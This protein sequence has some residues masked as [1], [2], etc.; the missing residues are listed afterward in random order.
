MS[1]PLTQLAKHFI[2]LKALQDWLK[3]QSFDAIK[4]DVVLQ[5]FA[6]KRNSTFTAGLFVNPHPERVEAHG[7]GEDIFWYAGAVTSVSAPSNQDIDDEAEINRVLLW[8]EN[9]YDCLLP[10]TDIA[11]PG[12]DFINSIEVQPGALFDQTGYA[13]MYDVSQVI[14]RGRTVK[15]RG[16]QNAS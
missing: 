7:S 14:V 15:T 4:R 10:L 3:G 16:T 1:K 2:F 9:M 5:R 13:L 6:F 11:L 12:C 8:R